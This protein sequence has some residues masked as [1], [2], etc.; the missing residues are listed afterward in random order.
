[1]CIIRV[2][3]RA[4]GQNALQDAAQYPRLEKYVK[5]TVKR[6]ANDSRILIWDIWNEPDNMTGPS[7]EKVELPNKVALILPLLQKSFTWARSAN[8]SQP[9]TS[10]I[11]AGDWSAEAKLKPIEKLQLSQSDV[12]SFHNYD[13][14][15]EL[16]KRIK[17]LQ[18]YNRPILCTEY[19]ARPN[20]S[21]FQSSLP[22][23]KKYKVAMYNWGFVD[24]KTQTIYPWDSWVSS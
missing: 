15:Q 19:M 7:Y 12:I 1:M 16:E 20:G 17:W 11:W 9:L 21:T 18:R 10:G 13:D 5:G 14:T 2:G 22:V 23:A 4:P 6:F 24:G 3:Y 8:P